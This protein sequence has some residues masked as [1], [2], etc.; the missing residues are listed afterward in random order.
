MSDSTRSP[1]LTMRAWT[2]NV[3]GIPSKVLSLSNE[4][5]RPALKSPTQVLVRVRYAA[6]N[7]GGSIMVQ[8]CPSILRTKPCIPEMDFAGEI[9]QVGDDAAATHSFKPG[10]EVFG[11]IPVPEHLNG[12]GALSEFVSVDAANILPAPEKVDLQ[13]AA[14]LPVAGHTALTLLDSAKLG[15]G[16]KVFINGALG[17]IGSMVTQMI[18]DAIGDEGYIV[19]TCSGEKAALLKDIGADMVIDHRANSP[20][21]QFLAEKY[22]NNKFDAVVD[23]Y[24]VQELVDNCHRFLKEGGPFVT[25]GIAFKEYTYCSMLFAVSRMLKNVLVPRFLGG[26]P[27]KYV[28][29][30]SLVTPE[31][32]ERL[33]KFCDD[34][35]MTVPID[36]CW[37]FEDVYKAYERML[38]SRA[39]GKIIVKIH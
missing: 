25:V 11:S 15:R 14:G 39:K 12:Q 4:V 10:V 9:V 24:G 33:K 26:P 18:R 32:L 35:K 38:S 2:H 13:E 6:L 34:G 28:Q 7:P 22:S 5:P 23:A 3:Q 37:E 31:G 29:V 20:V 17:G 8:L 19:A 27:R 36:S 1:L 21:H 16:Q 30:S